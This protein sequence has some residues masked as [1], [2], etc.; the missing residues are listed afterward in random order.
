MS[1]KEQAEAL[2]RNM[3]EREALA[4]EIEALSAKRD[5]FLDETSE[6]KDGFDAKVNDSLRDRAGDFGIAY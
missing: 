3:E 5:A 6:G 1:K 4:E 2:T